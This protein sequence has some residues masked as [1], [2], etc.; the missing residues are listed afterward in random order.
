[1]SMPSIYLGR[2]LARIAI[3]AALLLGPAASRAATDAELLSEART[4]FAPLPSDAAT[5]AF[6]I[7]PARVELGRALFFDTRLSVDGTTS[8]ASCH[9]PSLYGADGLVKSHGH[10]DRVAP[11]NAPTVLNSA[12]DISIHWLGDRANVE[13]QAVKALIGPPTMGNPNLDAAMAKIAAIPGYA[14]LFRAAFPGEEPA[15]TQANFAKAVGAY[16]RTLMSP[17]RFDEFLAGKTDAL[18][19][20]EKAGLA[21]FIE[22]GCI[23]CHNGPNVGGNSYQKFGVTADYWTETGSAQPDKGRVAFTKNPDDTYVF[24]VP[25]LRNVAMTAPYFHDGSVVGLSDA[26]RIMGRL[27]LGKDLTD[28]ERSDIV[29]FLG[30]LTGRMPESFVSAPILPPGAFRATE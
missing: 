4:H 27:Q 24:K 1:M 23:A 22:V 14:P 2:L 13:E 28:Q 26:V 17:G 8:C 21:T 12:T 15:L 5:E 10:H 29:A 19:A 11:R 7:P 25:G 9:P 3:A 16:E 18:S 30:S 6:P 20:Q